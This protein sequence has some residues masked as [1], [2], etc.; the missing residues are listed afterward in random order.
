[1]KLTA[2]RLITLVLAIATIVQV[3]WASVHTANLPLTSAAHRRA[4]FVTD[5]LLGGM[6]ISQA[7]S[8]LF[9]PDMR[10]R[11]TRIAGLFSLAVGIFCIVIGIAIVY[12]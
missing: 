6:L 3:I 9:A 12:K 1:M 2:A 11:T 7:V 5:L 4:S 8:L 10:G